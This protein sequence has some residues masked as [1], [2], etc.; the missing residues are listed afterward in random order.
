MS[1]GRT[2]GLNK[3]D[4]DQEKNTSA[5]KNISGGECLPVGIKTRSLTD[6]SIV[7]TKAMGPPSVA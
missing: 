5:S 6:R 1:Q 2:R 4:T 7:F 3:Q